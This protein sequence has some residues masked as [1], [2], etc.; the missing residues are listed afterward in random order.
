MTRG[1][2]PDVREA[3]NRRSMA[4]VAAVARAR[5]TYGR[6]A[7]GIL[8]DVCDSS[9]LPVSGPAARSYESGRR[10]ARPR[11]PVA[12]VRWLRGSAAPRSVR[13]AALPVTR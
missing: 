11:I 10:L 4:A 13:S 12:S 9:R 3:L 5:M 7:G 2:G 8:A 1:S 6:H